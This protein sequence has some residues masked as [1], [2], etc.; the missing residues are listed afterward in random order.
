MPENKLGNETS[1]YLLQHKDNPVHWMAWGEE[2]FARARDENKPILLS[3][4]YAACHWCHVMA[5]E[6]FEDG[7]ISDIMNDLMINIKVD[8]EERPDID[9]IYQSALSMMGEQ[10][11]W[12]L[13][14]FLTPAGEPFW[15]GTY[16]PPTP[17]FGRPGFPDVLRAVSNTFA[18]EPD[19][20]QKNVDALRD[21]LAQNSQPLGGDTISPEL[22]DQVAQRLVNEIDT[23]HG[24]IKGAPKFP[25]TGIFEQI[26]RAWL[27]TQNDLYKTAVETSLNNICQGGIYDHLG[28]GFARYSVDERWLAPHFE[29]MLYDNAE[30]I[31]L[32]TLV[33]QET[34]S[35][36]YAQRVAETIE[37]LKR[38]MIETGGGFASSLDADSEGEEGKFYVWNDVE[39]ETILAAR[40][41]T[42][43]KVYDIQEGGNWEGKTI[44]NR[45]YSMDLL[46]DDTEAE[47]AASRNLLL[48]ERAHRIRPGKDTKVLA[49]W[50]GQMIAALAGASSAFGKPEWLDLA[51]SAYDFVYSNMIIGGRL[52]HS[53]CAG[54]AR[55]PATLD[56]HANMARA[57]LALYEATGNDTYRTNVKTLL[58]AVEDHYADPKG[59]YFFAAD[60]TPN[61]ITRTKSANDNAT[62]SGNG[63]LVGV[64]TKLHYLTGETEYR[65]KAE[66]ILKTF[67]GEPTRNF[68]PLSTLINASETL[69][70]GLQIVI[71]G[72]REAADT[73]ALLEII[74][75]HSLPDRILSIVAPT[76]A[77]PPKH[78]AAG[79]T[80]I[81]NRATAYICEGPVCSAPVNEPNTLAALLTGTH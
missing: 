39:V 75:S 10:G 62:P 34:K 5:H 66:N 70:R 14:M 31:H 11:G 52:L 76:D 49:D 67:A 22:V 57:G 24:G 63:T 7:D 25:Q 13:T 47:L 2:A 42:F 58:G 30:L 18:D 36:L 28:G 21:G 64:F 55:H 61:L 68:F 71:I 26:W 23:F 6:C 53:W 77:L 4:G 17:K 1:P 41:P 73:H 40:Y 37:W 32:L 60:D 9:T 8:R 56:D 69:R 20:V 78:P 79:K 16:F 48:A 46:D 45:L 72:G 43:K 80:Q 33:W 38:E 51:K 59:A 74:Q 12:P 44:L 65:D 15:G 29:K 27:R 50:N 54:S 19:R 81:D 3:V 35:P